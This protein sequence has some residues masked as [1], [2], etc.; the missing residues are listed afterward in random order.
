[1]L[2]NRLGNPSSVFAHRAI[3]CHLQAPG[4]RRRAPP[5]NVDLVLRY[6]PAQMVRSFQLP[7]NVIVR[8][9]RHAALG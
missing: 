1:M 6:G 8:V 2:P 4:E 7:Q 3:L 5:V 9:A